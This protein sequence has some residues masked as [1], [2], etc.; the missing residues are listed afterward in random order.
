MTAESEV[1]FS[2]D[3]AFND[4]K[5]TIL[6]V[7]VSEFRGTEYLSIREY[8]QDFDGGWYPSK[9]GVTMALTL[10]LATNLLEAFTELLTA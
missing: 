1:L 3:I 2:K 8:Y 10:D 9:D 7:V 5:G 4:M 6:R